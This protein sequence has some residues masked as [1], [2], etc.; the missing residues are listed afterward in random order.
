M[1]KA[2]VALLLGSSLAL[3]ACSDFFSDPVA[4]HNG[5]VD[6]MDAVL[7]AEEAFYDE[8]F[9]IGDGEVLI[10]LEENVKLFAQNADELD[11]YFADTKFDESQQSFVDV[12]NDS[13]KTVL[14]AYVADAELFVADLKK[15]GKT[16]DSAF[17]ESYFKKMDDHA[18][19]FVDSHNALIDVINAQA[20][21]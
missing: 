11:R 18:T 1:K 5:L 20:D 2:I 6:R 7:T 3:T 19:L 16:F 13:Y 8:Y 9:N 10:D 17:A 15:N 12:Y 4:T 14:E 21:Y